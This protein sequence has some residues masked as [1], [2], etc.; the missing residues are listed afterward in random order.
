MDGRDALAFALTCGIEW[1]LFAWISRLGGRRTAEFCFLLNGTTWCLA[2]G[3]LAVL[4]VPIP[5]IEAGIVFAEAALIAGYWS[6]RIPRALGVSLVLNL[7][8]WLLGTAVL[9]HLLPSA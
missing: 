9:E 2:M 6:W 8:S 7:T 1:P 4:P 3:V 5:W